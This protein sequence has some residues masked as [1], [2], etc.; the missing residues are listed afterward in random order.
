MYA[1]HKSGEERF[2]KDGYT[3]VLGRFDYASLSD[4]E[5]QGGRRRDNISDVAVL[6]VSD[7]GCVILKVD[8]AP[9]MR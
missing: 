1:R 5:H 2:Y 9:G 7:K 6:V 4:T 3:D 8:P